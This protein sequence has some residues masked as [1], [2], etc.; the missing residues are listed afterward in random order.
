MK[1]KVIITGA[2]GLLGSYFIKNNRNKYKFYKFTNKGINLNKNIFLKNPN[3][4]VVHFASVHKFPDFNLE[5]SK[6]YK[7]N[8]KIFEDIFKSFDGNINNFFFTSTIDCGKKN[9]PRFKEK[10]ISSKLY[11]EKK[12]KVFFEKKKIH[13]VYILRLPAIIESE[14]TFFLKSFLFKFINNKEIYF[15]KIPYKF[16]SITTRKDICKFIEKKIKIKSKKR[17]YLILN[18]PSRDPI[19]FLKFFENLKKK[20]QS[21]SI[22]KFKNI[23]Y[24]SSI[25]Y[26]KIHK[27]NFKLTSVKE[28]ITNYIKN[29]NEYRKKNN[30][31]IIKY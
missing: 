8:I 17:K 30:K 13:N 28:I 1:Y 14:T 10:Y 19:K 16:N 2:K 29:N 22:I 20:I 18:F 12:F 7:K 9:Y 6:N 5:S 11:I 31:K 25:K 23:D 3:F 21:K 15:D 24:S 27:L 26:K 4:D